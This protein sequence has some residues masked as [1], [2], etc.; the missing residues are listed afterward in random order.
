M[1]HRISNNLDQMLYKKLTHYDINDVHCHHDFLI[2][3][4]SDKT[5]SI[6]HMIENYCNL[7][8]YFSTTLFY[9]IS[10]SLSPKNRP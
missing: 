5:F 2:K 9:N 4:Y 3:I 1:R 8:K 7:Q 10:L 6:I